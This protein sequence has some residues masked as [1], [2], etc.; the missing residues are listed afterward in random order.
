MQEQAAVLYE[1]LIKMSHEISL[2]NI[3]D[4]SFLTLK[5]ILV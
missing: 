1:N 2:Q 5:N 4:Y 3:F